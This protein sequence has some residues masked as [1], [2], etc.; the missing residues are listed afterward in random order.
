MTY[1]LGITG[2]G[3]HNLMTTSKPLTLS[4]AQATPG[5]MQNAMQ[6]STAFLCKRP[7]GSQGVYVL[8]A[9]RSTPGRPVLLATRP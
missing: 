9:E 8:D 2:V 3:A 7:D 1:S 5:G 4:D 6:N